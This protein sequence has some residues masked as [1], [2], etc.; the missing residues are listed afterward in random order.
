MHSCSL[1]FQF[2][3]CDRMIKFTK[4]LYVKNLFPPL[5]TYLWKSFSTKLFINLVLKTYQY[6]IHTFPSFHQLPIEWLFSCTFIKFTLMPRPSVQT[7]VFLSRTKLKL[8]W[9]IFGLWQNILSLAKSLFLLL[10]NS[11]KWLF[12]SKSWLLRCVFVKGPNMTF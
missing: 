8:S 3:E 2:L 9:T 10:I 1:F 11:L 4:S 5:H 12:L 7:K 6:F